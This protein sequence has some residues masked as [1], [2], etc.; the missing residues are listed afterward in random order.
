[1]PENEHSIEDGYVI[2]MGQQPR[3]SDIPVDFKTYVVLNKR[4]TIASAIRKLTLKDINGH[5]AVVRKGKGPKAR[6]EGGRPPPDEESSKTGAIERIEYVS[7]RLAAMII[8][9]LREDREFLKI[10]K[11]GFDRGEQSFSTAVEFDPSELDF[12]GQ[13]EKPSNDELQNI[14]QGRRE[15]VFHGDD[16]AATRHEEYSSSPPRTRQECLVSVFRMAEVKLKQMLISQLKAD[17]SV[18]RLKITP[19][20][21]E[22]ANDELL[23]NLCGL[24]RRVSANPSYSDDGSLKFDVDVVLYA[25]TGS[26]SID[27]RSIKWKPADR[28]QKPAHPHQRLAKK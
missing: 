19:K 25:L 20:K 21:W 10:N 26:R 6:L 9:K 12:F 11:N 24:Q 3:R 14:L 7:G 27:L 13:S 5:D 16:L 15:L 17:M 8:E 23:F 4:E 2:P 28:R 1:M 18:G 22:L